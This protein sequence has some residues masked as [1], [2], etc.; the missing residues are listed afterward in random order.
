MKLNGI[1][2]SSVSYSNFRTFLQGDSDN[3]NKEMG[4]DDERP[5]RWSF[6]HIY[7]FLNI[8]FHIYVNSNFIVV[9]NKFMYQY[10]FFFEGKFMFRCYFLFFKY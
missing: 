3:A 5:L 6:F 2:C 4:E 1:E 8:I 7:V 10:F 9:K